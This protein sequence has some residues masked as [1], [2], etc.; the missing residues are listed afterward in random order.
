MTNKDNEHSTKTT[1]SSPTV[2]QA[3]TLFSREEILASPSAFG[4]R[5]EVLAGA[6][7]LVKGEK[8]TRQQV[9]QAID[10]FRKREVK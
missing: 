9:S 3:E 2:H 4:V 10:K 8:M 7:T 6:L 5:S 1:K